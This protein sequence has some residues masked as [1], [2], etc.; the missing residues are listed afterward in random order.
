MAI[1]GR[2]SKHGKVRKTAVPPEVAASIGYAISQR[3]RKRI[4][5]C[6]GWS[7]TVGGIAQRRCAASTKFA[8]YSSSPWPPITSSACLSSW[9][10]RAKCV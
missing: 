3:L 10:R 7:K 1:N 6:F 4:E 8:P 5:E 9:P 2:V